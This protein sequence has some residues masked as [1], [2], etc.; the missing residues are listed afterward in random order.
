MPRQRNVNISNSS[1][2]DENS[3]LL[4]RVSNEVFEDDNGIDIAIIPDPQTSDL[5]IDFDNDNDSTVNDTS[6]LSYK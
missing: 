4:D 1:H 2:G 6:T 3:C 5:K